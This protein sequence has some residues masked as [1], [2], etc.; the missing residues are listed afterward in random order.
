[1]LPMG[2]LHGL[3]AGGCRAQRPRSK[4][5]NKPL[6]AGGLVK[7]RSAEGGCAAATISEVCRRAGVRPPAVYH[8]H[9]SKD[10]LIAAVVETVARPGLTE[11]ERLARQGATLEERI[12]AVCGWRAL[13]LEPQSPVLL[14]IRVQLE[15]RDETSPIRSHSGPPRP[16]VRLHRHPGAPREPRPIRGKG[17]VRY[18]GGVCHLHP[19][20]DLCRHVPTKHELITG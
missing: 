5:C 8:H 19:C 20:A 6:P 16:R 9:G 15:C 1:L 13:L 12:D 18:W 3:A 14:L 7:R 10:G 4:E 11:L 17:R 2:R